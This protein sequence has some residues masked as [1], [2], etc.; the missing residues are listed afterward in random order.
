MKTNAVMQIA[1]AFLTLPFSASTV[2]AGSFSAAQQPIKLIFI[3]H[4][5]GENWLAD[6]YGDLG[7][8]LEQN[9][10][11]V[12]DTNYGWGP[13]KIGSR[14]DIPN[15]MEWFRSEATEQ[16]TQA[17]FNESGQH[18]KYTRKLADPGGENQ[19]IVFK[20]CFP[21]SDLSGSPDDPPGAAAELSVSGAKYV[22]NEILKYFATRRDKMFVVITAPPL[23]G[24][25]NA[26][27]ARAFNQWLMNDWLRENR[28][29]T[30]NVFIFDF[31]NV[32]TSPDAHHRV[33]KGEVEYILGNRDTLAY[34]TTFV[35]AHPSVKGSQKATGDFVPLLNLFVRQ[36]KAGRDSVAA[37]EEG[38]DLQGETPTPKSPGSG[39]LMCG[40]ALAP[41][42]LALAAKKLLAL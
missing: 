25:K 5:T 10:Y 21:N 35:D 24:K 22:Y 14:T 28:Y 39:L 9:H 4:S 36:W 40:A 1:G 31:Y 11:F 3:H 8:T 30:G 12:S 15:W 34:P 16:V 42:V 2:G 6:G 41:V 20:S 7:R 29:E 23:I 26:A 13:D 33:R 27:N 19:I 17:L 37:Q 32:L 18:S 38:G